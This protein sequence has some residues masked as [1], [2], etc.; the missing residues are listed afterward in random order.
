MSHNKYIVSSFKK[1][2][3]PWVPAPLGGYFCYLYFVFSSQ[4][5]K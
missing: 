1:K 2:S 5:T 4:N 3:M